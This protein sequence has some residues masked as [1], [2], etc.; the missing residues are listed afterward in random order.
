MPE[1]V[2]AN[3]DIAKTPHRRTQ[4]CYLR[5]EEIFYYNERWWIKTSRRVAVHA[6]N[7]PGE[8]RRFKYNDCVRALDP[9]RPL[10]TRNLGLSYDEFISQSAL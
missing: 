8:K 10:P 6:D 9:G 2:P 4:F 7:S 3:Q 5:E 1:I